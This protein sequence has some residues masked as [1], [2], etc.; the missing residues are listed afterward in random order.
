MRPI[1]DS[2][3]RRAILWTFLAAWLFRFALALAIGSFHIW[4]A[5]TWSGSRSRWLKPESSAT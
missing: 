4:T 2:K 1:I 5:A 3:A